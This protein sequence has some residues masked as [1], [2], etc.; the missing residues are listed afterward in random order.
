M[1]TIVTSSWFTALPDGYMRIGISRGQPRRQS[2]YRM[3]RKLAPGPWFN[4][5]TEDEYRRR[6]MAQLHALDA[7]QVVA[8]LEALAAGRIPALLCYERPDDGY[9]CHRGFVSAWLKDALGLD[10]PEYGLNGCGWDH[11]KLPRKP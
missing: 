1:L 5:V 3:Y 6:Y 8:D 2:G 7:R 9:F 4:S 11:P 10:V